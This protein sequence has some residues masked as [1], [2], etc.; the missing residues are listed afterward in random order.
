MAFIQRTTISVFKRFYSND[1]QSFRVAVV[2]G[3]AGGISVA[4][5]LSKV[6]PK[7]SL[8]VIEPQQVCYDE[9]NMLLIL[10]FSAVSLLSTSLDIG[11]WRNS[12]FRRLEKGYEICDSVKC[13]L[14]QR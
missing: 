3:G 5:R 2:G 6:L 9:L 10:L 11:G 1:G 12:I 4:A 13:D 14:D 8:A 7:G